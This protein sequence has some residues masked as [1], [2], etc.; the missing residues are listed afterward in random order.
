M[1]CDD[2]RVLIGLGVTAVLGRVVLLLALLMS[3]LLS[4][5]LLL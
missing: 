1:V 3:L 4:I 2:G 5:L